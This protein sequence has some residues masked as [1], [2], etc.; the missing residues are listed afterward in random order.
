VRSLL[1]VHGSGSGPWAFEG[2]AATF[3]GVEVSAVDLQEGLDVANATIDDYAAAVVR[4]AALLPRPLAVVGW[5]LGGL[6]AMLA[7]RVVRPEAL[8]L[9][10]ASPPL[11]VQGL[12]EIEPRPGTFDPVEAGGRPPP[13]MRYRRESSLAMGQRD[14]GVPVAELPEGTRVLVVYTATL[15]HDRGPVL[16][17]H[18]GADELDVGAATHWDLVR[19]ADVRARV[20]A[21]LLR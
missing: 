18:L 11:E 12:R 10:E 14:R 3:P 8:V 7:A 6:V 1:L 16:A 9:L 17:A 19:D 5:S 15:A 4:A 2:W 20:A 21:W 13:G